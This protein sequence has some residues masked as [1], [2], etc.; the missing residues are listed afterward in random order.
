MEKAYHYVLT[1]SNPCVMNGGGVERKK[2]DRIQVI[3]SPTKSLN[4]FKDYKCIILP[5]GLMALLVSDT[6]YNLDKLDQEEKELEE[7]KM[8]KD[9]EENEKKDSKDE[10]AESDDKQSNTSDDVEYKEEG[11]KNNTMKNSSGLKKS[12]AGLCIGMGSFSDPEDLQGN[13]RVQKKLKYAL[14]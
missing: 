6:S 2:M 12:A 7:N 5:N 10:S 11:L 4:D 14:T 13:V 8:V 1:K 9:G 3:P